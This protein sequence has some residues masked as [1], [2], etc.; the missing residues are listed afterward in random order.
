MSGQKQLSL[1]IIT[2]ND[3]TFFPGCLKDMEDACDEM[4]V[5]DL[6][7][8]DRT[9]E[10]ARRAGAEV[11][12]PDWKDDFSQIKNFCMDC[13]AG[14]WVLFL[15]ADEV[16]S[17]DQL[18]ELKLLMQNPAAEG[19]L[20]DV[21][22]RQEERVVSSPVQDLRMIR[23]RK[24][25]RF[26]YRCVEYIP[27][28]ELYSLQKS[29]LRITHRREK[30][31]GWQPEERIRL[32]QLDL[33][34][35]PQDGYICYLEGIE[36]L[37]QK[38]YEESAAFFELACQAFGGGY[39]YAPHLYKCFSF[40]LMSLGRNKDAEEVLNEGIWLFPFYTDLLV[41]RA[42]LFHRLGRNEKA[43][44]DLQT[45]LALRKGHTISVPVPEIDI[46]AIEEMLE[47]ILVDLAE[48]P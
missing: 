23:N 32:L 38:K 48:K 22:D 30:A 44:K 35:H 43:L 46:S 31:V 17:H 1:C 45:G 27:D 28:E 12:Q 8:N 13:A 7:S 33:N 15:Q 16:I 25:Y 39:L 37:N 19:Y 3:E 9:P 24:N 14:K 11:Y 10:L 2:K 41:L 47:D 4:L 20:I 6:G 18:K 21:E 29:G 42:E 34:E 26:R 36:L 5:V 40:C